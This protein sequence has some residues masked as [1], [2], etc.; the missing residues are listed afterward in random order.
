MGNFITS[1]SVTSRLPSTKVNE[2]G[3][4]NDH[5][6]YQINANEA[7]LLRAALSEVHDWA[8]GVPDEN[9]LW[10]LGAFEQATDPIPYGTTPAG[11]G[12]GIAHIF[13]KAAGLGYRRSGQD[14][15]RRLH[16]DRGLGIVELD[17]YAGA[18]VAPAGKFWL[19]S[20]AGTPQYSYNGGGWA[21]FG[22]G[23]SAGDNIDWTGVHDFAA[24]VDFQTQTNFHDDVSLDGALNMTTGS[25]VV[26]G[27]NTLVSGDKLQLAQAVIASMVRGDLLRVNAAGTALE[28]FPIGAAG[29]VIAGS[30]TD[31][32]Y[33]ATPTL[34]TLGLAAGSAAAASLYKTGDANTG[35][36]FPANDQVAMTTAGTARLIIDTSTILLALPVTMPAGSVSVPSGAFTGDPNT[37]HYN[38]SADV[39]GISAGGV[40]AASFATGVQSFFTDILVQETSATTSGAVDVAIMRARS[41]GTTVGGGDSVGFGMRE[42]YQLEDAAGNDQ[43]AGALTWSWDDATNGSEDADLVLGLTRAGTLTGHTT[44][45]GSSGKILACAGGTAPPYAF[46][47]DEDSGIGNPSADVVGTYAN[48]AL[49]QKIG[50]SEARWSIGGAAFETDYQVTATAASVLGQVARGLTVGGY[51]FAQSD[52]PNSGAQMS[53]WSSGADATTF[54]GGTNVNSSWVKGVGGHLSVGTNTASKNLYLGANNTEFMQ[55]VAGGQVLFTQLMKWVSGNEQTTVGAAGAASAIPGNPT[56]WLK[57]KGSDGTTLVIP[58]F[59]AA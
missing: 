6:E 55:C 9:N 38:P 24:Q 1:A 17:S 50:V 4:V 49:R 48:G 36:Y 18:T 57:V 10:W 13:R 29:T 35:V 59:L 53:H 30:A 40:L 47:G 46:S 42:L 16:D 12:T 31:P 28:R 21:A 25:G 51:F 22:G 58:A 27:A 5:P 39:Y 15:F 34:T 7:N 26:V 8:S 37:G 2:P 54:C 44:F 52:D 23:L 41:T 3:R 56:K 14:E 20:N 32:A 11:L 19:R 33:T 43:N 45:K